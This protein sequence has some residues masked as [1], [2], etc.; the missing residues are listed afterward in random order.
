MSHPGWLM[1]ILDPGFWNNPYITGFSYCI[2]LHNPNQ[3]GWTND[4][5]YQGV[6]KCVAISR[7]KCD[8][9]SRYV[10]SNYLRP[11]PPGQN[12]Q[13]LMIRAYENHWFPLRPAIKP[14]SL[15]GGVH[16]RGGW[17][18]SQFM[19]AWDQTVDPPTPLR[20]QSSPPESRLTFLKRGIP[21]KLHLR[22]WNTGWV[23]QKIE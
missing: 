2:P 19:K 4:H 18:I 15:R 12:S 22:H 17:L 21:I 11:R 6:S 13:T 1:G 10:T 20:M 16:D 8:R 7:A 14:L 23:H 9:S 3:S 5:C